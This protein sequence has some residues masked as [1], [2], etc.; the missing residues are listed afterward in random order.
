[1]NIYSVKKEI[2]AERIE[3]DLFYL[4]SFY[5]PVIIE[6]LPYVSQVIDDWDYDNS[7]MYDV[8]TDRL[9]IWKIIDKVYEKCSYL[10]NFYRPV[11]EEDDEM[12]PSGHCISCRSGDSWLKNIVIMLVVGEL[13]ERRRRKWTKVES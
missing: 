3:Q 5:S 1:M 13:R 4:Q 9:H 10:E 8:Y 12:N 7:P 6:I 11:G 2:N